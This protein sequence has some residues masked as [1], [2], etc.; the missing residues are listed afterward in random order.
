MQIISQDDLN[1]GTKIDLT[2]KS[3]V[4]S[5]LDFLGPTLDQI[6]NSTIAPL[7]EM[8]QTLEMLKKNISEIDFEVVEKFPYENFTI[9]R[10]QVDQLIAGLGIYP[11]GPIFSLFPR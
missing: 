6:R 2:V 7:E 11:A 9:L 3:A 10:N 5:S 8:R 1:L 4:N